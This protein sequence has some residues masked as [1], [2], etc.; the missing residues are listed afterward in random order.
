MITPCVIVYVIVAAALPSLDSSSVAGF[1]N[2][3]T[4]TQIRDLDSSA[5]ESG[6]CSES[7]PDEFFGFVGLVPNLGDGV[8]RL[9]G[10]IAQGN[11]RLDRLGYGIRTEGGGGGGLRGNRG[12]D[13]RLADLVLDRKS[14]V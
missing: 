13:V 4:V 7:Q 8:A 11:H 14:V 10:G 3:G 1:C 9:G 6:H 5:S 2:M 12:G